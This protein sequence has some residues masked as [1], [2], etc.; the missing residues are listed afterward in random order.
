MTPCRSFPAVVVFVHHVSS[1]SPLPPSLLHRMLLEHYSIARLP[2]PFLFYPVGSDFLLT[3][4]RT[5]A[6][7][8]RLGGRSSILG[9][10]VYVCDHRRDMVSQFIWY[11]DL[12]Q[13][14]CVKRNWCKRL[15]IIQ[16][17]RSS[18]QVD[19]CRRS[20][21]YLTRRPASGRRGVLWRILSVQISRE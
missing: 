21:R 16:D 20:R 5:I 18:I 14:G 15:G 4:V 6:S 1:C 17:R 12:S 9:V 13:N 3:L 11:T 19:R 8:C 2:Y 10:H 7:R